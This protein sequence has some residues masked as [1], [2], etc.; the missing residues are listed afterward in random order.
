MTTMPR[1]VKGYEMF[2]KI[3]DQ[4]ILAYDIDEET[5]LMDYSTVGIL[6]K[7]DELFAE[8]ICEALGIDSIEEYG[9]EITSNRH[10]IE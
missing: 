3:N 10:D 1:S 2:V 5:R 6:I 7:A 9:V 4:N 8:A